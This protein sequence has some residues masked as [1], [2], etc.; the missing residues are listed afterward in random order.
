MESWKALVERI[1]D[2]YRD[3]HVNLYGSKTDSAFTDELALFFSRSAIS[4]LA[5]KTTILE[6]VE[7]MQKDDL[8]IA[9]DSGGMHI[10]NMFG[11]PLI[12]LYGVTNCIATGPIFDSPITVIRPDGCPSKGGFPTEEIGIETVFKAVQS[13]LG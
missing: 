13:I 12:C 7:H 10:A 8:V 5:G 9:I 3:S 6:L 11:R 1:F 4:N 2:K